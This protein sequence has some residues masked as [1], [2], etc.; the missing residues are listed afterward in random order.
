[1]NHQ[2]L[3][4]RC[5]VSY[6]FVN[7]LDAAI[8][9]PS[10]LFRS[11]FVGTFT[12]GITNQLVACWPAHGGG[13]GEGGGGEL[14]GEETVLMRVYGQRTELFIDRSA[15]V[16]NM[17]LLHAHGLAAPL[18]C[19]FRNG[20]CYGFNPGRVADTAL[21]RDPHVSRLIA[22]TL[23]RMHS[24]ARPSLFPTLHKYLSLVPTHFDDLEKNHRFV[25]SIPSK[26]ELEREVSLLEAHLSGLGSPVVFCHNDLLVKNIIYQ[27]E[28]DRVIFIDFEYADNNYQALDI[29]NHFCEFGGVEKFDSSLYPEREFQLR[30]LRHY[31]DEWHRLA[32][33]GEA[34]SPRDVELLYVQV[35]K[36]ALV[37]PGA[38][39]HVQAAQGGVLGP[40]AAPTLL[41]VDGRHSPTQLVSGTSPDWPLEKKSS[42]CL[43]RDRS[44]LTSLP[45]EDPTRTLPGETATRAHRLLCRLR[46]DA[47]NEERDIF[48]TPRL[49]W[50]L[51]HASRPSS[52]QTWAPRALPEAPCL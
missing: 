24:E 14:G 27:Q 23:A 11:H 32:G 40:A 13:K 38:A 37:C 41:G 9:P 17:R 42:D 4:L 36:F 50:L 31:L 2:L 25:S 45:Y 26:G 39:G 6:A 21:V 51:L 30:W 35:N 5:R 1:M 19:A 33:R 3:C 7:A 52:P 10:S 47:T 44:A 48:A 12:D 34:A 46:L 16:L 15:E 8:P 20:L 43:L 18:H 49:F 29:G 22:Q 28:L